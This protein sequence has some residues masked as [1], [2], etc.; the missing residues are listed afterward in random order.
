MKC[1]DLKKASQQDLNK[2]VAKRIE[3]LKQTATADFYVEKSLNR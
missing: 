3:L 2:A 1:W